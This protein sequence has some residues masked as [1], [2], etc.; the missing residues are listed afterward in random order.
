MMEG[1]LSIPLLINV[2]DY[3]MNDI[4]SSITETLTTKMLATT[5]RLLVEF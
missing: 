2:T 3:S 4:E 1:Y 5:T